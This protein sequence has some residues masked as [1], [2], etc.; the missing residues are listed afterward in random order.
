MTLYEKLFDLKYRKGIPTHEL[1]HRFPK[2]IDRV[3]E[4]ALLDIPEN[5]LKELFHEKR[6]LARLKSLKK[7]LQRVA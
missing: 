6:I 2:H 1:A 4:V 5:T 3:N 7:Q